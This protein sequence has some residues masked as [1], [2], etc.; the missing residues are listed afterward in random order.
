MFSKAITQRIKEIHKE[1]LEAIALMGSYARNDANKY[2]DID[3][4][5]FLKEKVSDQPTEIEV[6]DS[7][8]IVISFCPKKEVETWFSDPEKVTE[9]IAGLRS[10]KSIWDPYGFLCDLRRKAIDFKW[11]TTLQTKANEYASRELVSWIEEVHKA[12]SG[13]LSDDIGRMLNGLFGLTYGLF[14]VLRV[15]SGIFLAGDNSFF[16]Q[17]IDYFGEKSQLA[18]LSKKAFGI[19][20]ALEIRDRVFAGIKLFDHITDLLLDILTDDDKKAILFVKD[21]IKKALGD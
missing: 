21:E 10:S 19:D 2:S 15:Q 17:V 12:L 8:Y 16:Q 1:K 6:V 5:C 4:V 7:K 18:I 11:D 3:I 20:N 13:L 9:C 14:K